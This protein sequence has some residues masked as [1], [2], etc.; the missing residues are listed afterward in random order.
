[1]FF[2]TRL[3]NVGEFITPPSV[4]EPEN[5]TRLFSYANTY[6]KKGAMNHRKA[7]YVVPE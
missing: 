1:M 4:P 3:R 5:H 6:K 2:S 7:F